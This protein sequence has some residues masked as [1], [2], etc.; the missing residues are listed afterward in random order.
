M[1]PDELTEPKLLAAVDGARLVYFDARLHDTALVVAQEVIATWSIHA[2]LWNCFLAANLIL[3][4]N[5]T[6]IDFPEQATRRGIP[7][8]IDA[9]KKREGLDDLLSL[10]SYA[11]CSANFP[12]ARL[13]YCFI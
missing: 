8:L 5:H 12:Q 7:I 9:E 11:I 1:I 3:K 10:S 13:L 4:V 6:R 2:F